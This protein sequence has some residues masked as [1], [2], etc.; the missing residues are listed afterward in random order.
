MSGAALYDAVPYSKYPYVQTHPDR[1]ATL[2]VLHGL[3][4]APPP[5]ARVLELGCGAGGNLMP[6]AYAEP[7]LTAVGVDYAAAAVADGRATAAELGLR[8][9]DAARGRR[10]RAERRRAR[11]LRLRDRPRAL[12]LGRAGRARR[13]AVRDRGPPGSRRA[14]RSSPIPPTRAATSAACCARWACSTRATPSRRGARGGGARAVRRAG[15]AAR[16]SRRRVRGRA[17]ARAAAAAVPAGGL[18]RPRRPG[19]GRW[20]RSGSPT[21]RRTPGRTGSRS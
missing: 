17:R 16:R 15:R 18:A 9:V 12:R 1:L 7:G 20:S 6:M 13:A 5:A 4:P 19:R 3:S 2:A 8:N 14:S 11:E 21:S 10:A